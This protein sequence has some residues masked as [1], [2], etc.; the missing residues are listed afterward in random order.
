LFFP[1]IGGFQNLKKTRSFEKKNAVLF[2]K[3]LAFFSKERVLGFK[4]KERSI[5]AVLFFSFKRTEQKQVFEDGKKE[6][7]DCSWGQGAN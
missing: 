3:N 4:K 6:S 7:S 2:P 5:S 1:P